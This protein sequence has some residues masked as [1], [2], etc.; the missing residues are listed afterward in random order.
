MKKHIF[1]AGTLAAAV[2]GLTL[3][4]SCGSGLFDTED[5]DTVITFDVTGASLSGTSGFSG[6]STASLVLTLTNDSYSENLTELVADAATTNVDITPYF[7]LVFTD[8]DGNRQDVLTKYTLTATSAVTDVKSTS[9]ILYIQKKYTLNATLTYK[10]LSGLS[11][12]E[13]SLSVQANPIALASGNAARSVTAGSYSIVESDGIYKISTP[14]TSLIGVG[15][16]TINSTAELSTGTSALGTL[17]LGVATNQVIPAGTKIGTGKAG[18]TDVDLY[19]AQDTDADVGTI[20]VIVHT[21]DSSLSASLSKISNFVISY[22]PDETTDITVTSDA[23]S[24]MRIPHY[25][26]NFTDVTDPTTVFYSKN[27]SGGLSIATDIAID[28]NYLSFYSGNTNGKNRTAHLIES[29][30]SAPTSGSYYV[31]FDAALYGEANYASELAIYTTT[32]DDDS[33]VSDY[34]F[35]IKT[36]ALGKGTGAN[37][38]CTINGSTTTSVTMALGYARSGY[39]STPDW[40]HYKLYVDIASSTATM[41]ITTT[42]GDTLFEE[43]L[44]TST[45]SYAFKGINFYTKSQFVDPICIDNI[46]IYTPIATE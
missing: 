42:S 46:A 17:K 25:G 40:Y 32:P 23:G 16:S 1:R 2:A 26:E 24:E 8:S 34:L 13:G 21:S 31:E 5:Q 39:V 36:P 11:T 9:D 43:A 28:G 37:A 6:D 33:Y 22:I 15:F 45:S 18:T 12:Q 14:A 41:T 19:A 27:A 35:S 7:S 3:L 38:T 29:L 20:T 44:S 4:A 30:I 10:F